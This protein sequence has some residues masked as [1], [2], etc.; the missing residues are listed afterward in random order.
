MLILCKA[1]WWLIELKAL[2][3]STNRAASISESL[4]I[5]CIAW[6]AASHPLSWPAYSWNEPAAASTSLFTIL[7]TAFGIIHLGTSPTPMSHFWAFIERNKVT[8]HRPSGWVGVVA[9]CL[10]TLANAVQRLVEA[11]LNDKDV[12]PCLC[13]Q[14]RRACC[15]LRNGISIQTIE[16]MPLTRVDDGGFGCLS[17]R[18]SP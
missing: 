11:Y 17:S 6:T 8:S 5:L 3:A 1:A 12:S 9:V 7:S 14:T 4:K 10:P 13:I 15:S 2:V 16:E 18:I